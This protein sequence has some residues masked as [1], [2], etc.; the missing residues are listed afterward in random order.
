MSTSVPGPSSVPPPASSAA[1]A[2][3][4]PHI[5]GQAMLLQTRGDIIAL[6]PLLFA[7]FTKLRA[8][9]RATWRVIAIVSV[10][11]VFPLAVLTLF[12]GSEI[13]QYWGL[14]LYFSLFWACFFGAIYHTD[15]VRVPVAVGTF[16]FT[17][18][19][20]MPLLLLVLALGLQ[21]LRTPMVES[22]NILVSL[23]SMVIFVGLFEET[24]KALALFGIG[25]FSKPLPALRVF[26]FYG[27]ISGLGFGI[28]EGISYQT[29]TNVAAVV[30]TGDIG[31]YYLSNVLRL[32]SAPFFH[33]VW[34]AIAAFLIWFGFRFPKRRLGFFALAILV[35]AIL[36]GVYDAFVAY[37]P[38]FTLASA[39]VSIAIL[40]VYVA[41]ADDLQRDIAPI[42]EDQGAAVIAS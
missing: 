39:I 17:G 19:I 12:S 9:P 36:H 11:G 6:G 41:S 21:T 28:Y 2:A 7:P 31:A 1:G 22:A 38:M 5:P 4:R 34:T 24:T 18:L 14:A 20:A 25:L 13:E 27:L 33:A 23:P 37:Q 35:P 42:A 40:S 29:G 26:V 15:G 32:T 8:V 10:A 30:N 16:F 3:S